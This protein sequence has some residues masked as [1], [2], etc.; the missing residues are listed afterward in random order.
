[1]SRRAGLLAG[2]L[3]A[4]VA[5]VPAAARPHLRP[6][7]FRSC[8]QLVRYARAHFAVTG[9]VPET[10]IGVDSPPRTPPGAVAP[11]TT[12]GATGS[13]GTSFSTTNDQEAGVDEPDLVKTDGQTLFSV[14]NGTVHAVAVGAGAPRLLDTLAVSGA[15]QLLL[16]GTRLIVISGGGPLGIA[17]LG[18][19]P[20]F[21]R[22]T[23]TV[24]EVDV[25][26]PA[27]MRIT[28]TLTI[29]G[30]FV[31]ARQNGSTARLVISSQPRAIPL[32]GV[33]TRASGWVPRRRFRSRLT[34][35][36]SVRPVAGCGSIRRP[37]QF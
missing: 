1:M 4:L 6:H 3:M 37:V 32:A 23:T 22:P 7:A 29:D 26:D 31:D 28:R 12:N 15:S 9:G 10:A 24:T 30:S 11:T 36:H 27:A 17:A 35:R 2:L 18:P 19:V 5:A 25:H 21:F 13:A 34:G 16:R 8:A 20:P 33:R 14:A